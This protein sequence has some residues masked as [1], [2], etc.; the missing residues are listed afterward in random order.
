M[1][2]WTIVGIVVF[3]VLAIYVVERV[4]RQKKIN[5]GSAIKLGV[6]SAGLTSGVLYAID[7]DIVSTVT[8]I[9]ETAQDMF[10]GKPSF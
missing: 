5:A 8:T 3:A 10:V 6:L 1:I 7:E 2:D 4:T 9:K